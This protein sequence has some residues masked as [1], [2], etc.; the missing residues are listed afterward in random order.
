MPFVE[1]T[2]DWTDTLRQ[3]LLVLRRR[4][5]APNI[6]R[7]CLLSASPDRPTGSRALGRGRRIG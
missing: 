7:H 1:L 6:A 2:T 3:A 5:P 4:S